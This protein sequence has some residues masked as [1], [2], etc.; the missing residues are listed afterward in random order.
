MKKIFINALLIT[1][2]VFTITGCSKKVEDYTAPFEYVGSNDAFLKVIYASAYALN[3]G[4]QLSIDDKR[5]SGLITS[6][7][8][9]PGGGYNTQGSNFPDFL[10]V[11]QGSR[12]LTI[13]I[14]K[15]GTDI[16]SVV[17]FSTQINLDR[18]ANY[19]LGIM[20]TL[21]NT[22]ALLVDDTLAKPAYGKIKYRFVNLMP[23]APSLDL[24]YGTEKIATGIAYNTPGV[25][26]TMSVPLVTNQNWAIRE[27][28]SATNLATYASGSSVLNQRQYTIFAMGY[29]GSTSAALKP[30]VSFTLIR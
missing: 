21:A 14:P 11:A 16:D 27:T 25:V 26:F 28:G 30:Y 17:L 20:D 23:N 3:P 24:Y 22:K 19:T 2:T 6:R 15:K 18:R 9:F 12:K 5:V 10:K 7:T 13:A 1:G 4:V 29:K 8:P